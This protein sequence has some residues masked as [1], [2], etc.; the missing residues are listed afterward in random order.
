VE[1]HKF[2]DLSDEHAASFFRAEGKGSML[3]RNV[4]KSLSY[5]M[6][7]LVIR[8]HY[9]VSSNFTIMDIL[10]DAFYL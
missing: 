5:Y 1:L 10:G 9:P 8:L 6:T 2:A 7:S 3:L 4:S